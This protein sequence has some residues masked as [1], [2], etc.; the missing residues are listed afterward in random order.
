VVNHNMMIL[1]FSVG[2]DNYGINVRDV[3]EVLPNVALKHFPN[4]P[5]YVA[6]LL[7]YRGQAVP[8]VDLTLLMTAQASRNRIS[9]RI[10]LVDY[11]HA[12]ADAFT[13]E[14]EAHHLLGLLVE[15][16]TETMRVPDHAF[17]HSGV[18]TPDTPFLGDIAIHNEVMIQ[19]IDIK[20]VLPES[21]KTLL[22]YDGRNKS[23]VG[24]GMEK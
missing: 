22:F 3:T 16:I 21:V 18:I 23:A 15:K 13:D 5:E 10:V 19:I 11:H 6:G 17:T 4:G 8:V 24:N 9:S 1:L 7:N 20:R 12:F 14:G 2:G